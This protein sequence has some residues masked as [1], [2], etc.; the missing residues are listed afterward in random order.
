MN[1]RFT[2]RLAVGLST[3]VALAAFACSGSSSDTGLGG[4]SKNEAPPPPA[5]KADDKTAT[6]DTDK[7]TPAPEAPSADGSECGK[8]ATSDACADCCIAKNPAAYDAAGKVGFDCICAATTC[9]T[10][11][12]ESVCAAADNQ[13]E[14]TAACKTCLDANDQSCQDKTIAACDANADCKAIDAC[15]TSACDPI[16][17][18]EGSA[19][20][21][22]TPKVF[23]V[24]G[25]T[26]ASRRQ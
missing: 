15:L 23:S 25:A 24:R 22:A 19:G 6:T 12:A 11:C 13:N 10:A 16:A 3:F 18:K 26:R 21:G 7:T 20:G 8:K 4:S 1:H 14:P 17:Q 9:Q 2:S 5:K